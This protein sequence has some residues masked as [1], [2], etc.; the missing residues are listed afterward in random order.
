MWYFFHMIT[1]EI[2]GEKTYFSPRL[3]GVYSS[4][5]GFNFFDLD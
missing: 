4:K 1:G 2:P 5:Y 3:G